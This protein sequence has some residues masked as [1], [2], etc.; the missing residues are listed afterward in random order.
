MKMPLLQTKFHIPPVR[1]E[2]VHRARLIDLLKTRQQHKLTLLTAPAGFGKTTL[3]A[4]WLSEQECP[5][6][7]VSLDESDNDPIRFFS[8]VISA[9]DGVTAVRIGQT[10]LN[11]LHSSEPASPNTL[12]AYLIND[13]V[14]LNAD[15]ILALDDYHRIE[16]KEIHAALAFLLDNQPPKLH[17]VLISRTEPPL[18]LAKLRARHQLA[19]L[20]TFD[21]R[22]SH[23][24]IDQFLNQ[25]MHLG[26]SAQQVTKLGMQ[27]EGWVTALQLVALTVANSSDAGRLIDNI[28]GDNRYIA[29]YLV[30]EVLSSQPKHVEQF[31]L[32]TSI[33]ERMNADL[34]NALCDRDDSQQQLEIL[35][36]ANLFV[37]P[38]DDSRTWYRYHHLFAELL[39]NRLA[40][41]HA[42]QVKMLHRRAA[43]WFFANNMI[44]EAI[45]HSL[46]A[47]DFEAV[48]GYLQESIVEKIL[49]RGRFRTYLSWLE[50]I[51]DAALAGYPKLVLYQVFLLWEMQDLER[52]RRQL[53]LAE[54]MLGPSPTFPDDLDGHTAAYHG[55][56]AIIKGVE[57][58]GKFAT[59]QA[60][61]CFAQALSL[62]PEEYIFWRTL[63]LG[64]TG[65]CFR[66][67]GN[68]NEAGQCF[69]QVIRLATRSNLVFLCFM[70][71]IAQALVYLA[72][73]RLRDAIEACQIPLTLD[74][75][76]GRNTPFAG[77]AYS[78]MGILLY[79]ADDLP[80]AESHAKRGLELVTRDGDIYY[81]AD[82]YYTLARIHL[83]RGDETG[84]LDLM[85]QM[86]ARLHDMDAAQS[87]RIIARAYQAHIQFTCG[88]MDKVETWIANPGQNQLNA[89]QFPDILGLTYFGIYC[90][91]H[92]SFRD[93]I[94]LINLTVARY[95][96]VAGQAQKSIAITDGL[97][98][99]YVNENRVFFK[100]QV[101]IT[102]A[103]AL[104]TAGKSESAVATLIEAVKLVAPE[105]FVQPFVSQG[106]SI[107]TLLETAQ[108]KL[109]NDSDAD[110]T[111]ASS[112]AFIDQLLARLPQPQPTAQEGSPGASLTD[113]TPREIDVLMMLAAGVSYAEI[114]QRLM[115]SRNT[116]KTHLKHIYSKLDVGNR[117]QAIN[118]ARDFELLQ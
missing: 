96:L 102:R 80:A 66:V 53:A 73:G 38:L 84:A 107:K 7:W 5:V 43:G 106:R 42:D 2:L 18:P 116:V 41:Q 92:E 109:K 39:R 117:L 16:A 78:V 72:Q 55:I 52:Y 83:A 104:Q 90:T 30:D 69:S 110:A 68:Y 100:T 89:G 31:L 70:Y 12:L 56:L 24:E 111:N 93:Y 115:V 45:G 28:T 15:L 3:A 60:S 97:L 64:A 118:K 65:F 29:D 86:M 113:L 35:D 71:S 57:N 37:T 79:L 20:Q 67:E 105:P 40:D 87:G 34:C 88:H 11:L 10:A 51:P 22:F 14:N 9:L 95:E 4:S 21:L 49:A 77:L 63:A 48:T 75:E 81:M 85:D 46:E 23:D 19:E 108:T 61:S 103:L 8:Y 13:L 17:L 33:L 59:G 82:G 94:E 25:T 74:A 47:E 27:T 62:L 50:R 98:D 91:V 44:E 54:S 6:A 58:C 112:L 76:Q 101:L 114:A 26:L 32:Q 36:R 99:N 1:R